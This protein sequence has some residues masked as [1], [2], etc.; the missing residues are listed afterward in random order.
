MP[1]LNIHFHS[2]ELAM[3]AQMHVLLP[4]RLDSDMSRGT[5]QPGPYKTLYLLH[6]K[7]QDHTSWLRRTTLEDKVASLPL[8]VVMPNVHLSW[9]ADMKYGRRYFSFVTRELPRLCETMFNLSPRR[10]DRFVAGLS[11][12]GYGAIKV[13]L[14][15]PETFSGAMSMSGVLDM[16]EVYDRKDPANTAEAIGT[17]EE[18]RGSV[19]DLFASAERYPKDIDTR[20][21]L[22]CGTE[23]SRLEANRRWRD[24][25]RGLGL[26]VDYEDSPGEHDW[27]YW[28]TCI[29][30]MLRHVMGED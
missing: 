5:T 7:R 17:R 2:K 28:E 24:H 14:A 10:E 30:A 13:A 19:C 9:Y 22:C 21:Y 15:A 27:A 8:A 23:D 12:G 6:G 3:P 11:M 25:A 1:W 26:S 20:F 18:M 29:P 16:E 4:Q